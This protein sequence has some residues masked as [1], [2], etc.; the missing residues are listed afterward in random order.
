MKALYINSLENFSGKTAVCLALGKRLQAEGHRVGYLKPVSYQPMQVGGHVVDE[1]ASFVKNVMALELDPWELCPV[2]VS[3]D[4]PPECLTPDET[5]GYPEKVQE[6]FEKVQV[7]KDVVL[8]EGGGSLRQGYAIGLATPFVADMLDAAALAVVK[9]RGR[10]RMLDDAIAAQFRLGERLL[11]VVLNRIPE[12]EWEFTTRR[13]IPV[14]EKRGIRVLGALP[15]R[16]HLAAISVDELVETLNA[17]IITGEDKGEALIDSL[18]VG[19]MGAQEA[20]SRFRVYQNKAVITGGD[21]TDVQLAALETSTIALV[22]TGN[23]RPSA[24]VVERAASQGVVV[25]VVQHNTMEAVESIE[26]VFGKT[27]LGQA[28]KLAHFEALMAEHMDY[29]RF[30]ELLEL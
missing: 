27:R 21:R 8:L 18:M 3:P 25:M 22:L 16:P 30:F 28:E 1:D 17:R 10:I 23:L 29:K 9:F 15:E 7:D 11:G 20:L 19:A 24:A 5:C 12:Q 13:A 6:A 4:V 26:S 14:L 2:V